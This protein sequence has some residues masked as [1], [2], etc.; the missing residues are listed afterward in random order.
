[1]PFSPDH[2][3]ITQAIGAM[4]SGH[5]PDGRQGTGELPMAPDIWRRMMA[6]EIAPHEASRE[7]AEREPGQ[8]SFNDELR[9]QAGVG[10][11]GDTEQML[12]PEG[13]TGAVRD[14]TGQF[15]D[16][17]QAMREAGHQPVPGGI[18]PTEAAAPMDANAGI[19]AAY[20]RVVARREE[21]S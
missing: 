7:W 17:D 19:R 10:F 20:Q 12:S 6:G 15:A 9:R 14:A 8:R 1:M 18:T 21:R 3:A 4:R 16:L 5:N 13:G 2:A 11:T